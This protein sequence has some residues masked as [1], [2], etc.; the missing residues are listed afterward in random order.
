MKLLKFK[1]HESNKYVY[2]NPKHIVCIQRHQ[3]SSIPTQI[4]LINGVCFVID[5]DIDHVI[6]MV[7]N[8]NQ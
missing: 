2:I 6:N 8:C 7:Q 4:V 3:Q 5:E 1:R